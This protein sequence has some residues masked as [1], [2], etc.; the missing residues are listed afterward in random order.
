MRL[1]LTLDRTS[2]RAKKPDRSEIWSLPPTKVS[3]A[4][5]SV[6]RETHSLHPPPRLPGLEFWDP[7]QIVLKQAH[8]LF[9][10]SPAIVRHA[11]C[12]W[13]L[14]A[15]STLG[16]KKQI[17][18]RREGSL[19]STIFLDLAYL[20]M[21]VASLDIVVSN[22]FL[23]HKNHKTR[24]RPPLVAD[25]LCSLF[26]T[27]SLPIEDKYIKTSSPPV[28]SVFLPVAASSNLHLRF[29]PPSK[30]VAPPHI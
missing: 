10:P 12:Q 28:L 24:R 21:K 6:K 15:V 14:E 18:R 29:T 16:L 13:K 11:W 8:D 17:P 4:L 27:T 26:S 22:I 23:L 7:R 3:D 30:T 9:S 19:S 20:L 5:Q 2:V 1:M 25:F